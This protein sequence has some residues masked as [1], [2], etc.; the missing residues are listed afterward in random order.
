M[1]PI[2]TKPNLYDIYYISMSI[3]FMQARMQLQDERLKRL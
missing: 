1:L 3:K 2:K